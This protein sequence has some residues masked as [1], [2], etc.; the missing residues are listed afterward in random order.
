MTVKYNKF[1]V[2]LE[3]GYG[4]DTVYAQIHVDV[5][6]TETDPNEIKAAALA[7]Y[8]HVT[9]ARMPESVWIQDM[10]IVV[11][12][13]QAEP[14]LNRNVSIHWT[15]EELDGVDIQG[16]RDQVTAFGNQLIEDNR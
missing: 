10:E 16:F 5:P 11:K 8:T 1:F 3:L 7:A 12:D 2:T 13:I 15:E 14:A 6:T 9:G 4:I